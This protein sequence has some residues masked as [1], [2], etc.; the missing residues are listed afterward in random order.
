MPIAAVPG[1]LL[2]QDLAH[3]SPGMRFGMCL[4]IWT[5]RADQ[6]R[7]VRKRAEAKSREGDE[8]SQI[9]QR[10][11]MDAAIA[12]LM[13]RDRNKLPG[14]WD[15][16]DFAAREAWKKVVAL[17]PQDKQCMK[18][19]LERQSALMAALPGDSILCFDALATA[20]FTTGLGNEHPLE[21]G[22]AFLNPY[23]LPYL[24]ASG[25]KGVLRQ[26][27]RELA[28]G[29]WG[30]THGWSE[31]R[32]YF[33][34][35]AGGRGAGGEGL[36]TLDVLFGREPASGDTD[37][38]RGALIFWDVVPQIAGDSLMVEIMTPH[39]GHYYQQKAQAGSTSP[40]ESGQPNPISFLTV[41]PGSRFVF[42]VQCDLSHLNRLAP[43]L[44]AG[45]RWKTLLT[46]AFEHA[47]QW[48]GFGA[49]T[50]VGYGAMLS[51][52]QRLALEEENKERAARAQEAARKEK[53]ARL[54]QQAEPWKGARIKF[55]RSNGA[56]TVEKD[57]RSA[58]AIA[59]KG[60]ELLD[61]LPAEIRQKVMTNQFVRVTAYVSEGT[62]VRV[63]TP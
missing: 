57:G 34:P 41:P 44:A 7:Q 56:L 9:L 59:P 43:E 31:E 30:E 29:D 6:E 18:G 53:E 40:H 51:E 10:Q 25:V 19:L 63:E 37:H 12:A 1:Y 8:I 23:G 42:H 2:K 58:V 33:L 38:L 5:D 22:F 36:S 17:L 3:A 60:K 50:S 27:A 32:R 39:Q 35:S 52:A 20:P 15:K 46:A 62:L 45:D 28:S 47:F 54:Q 49:K 26:A 16:N 24:P 55:N 11:G 14:L 4:P 21:N 13:G 48:L 61:T